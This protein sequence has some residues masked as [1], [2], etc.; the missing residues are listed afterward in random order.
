M[1]TSGMRRR[2]AFDPE[3]RTCR[4]VPGMG[5]AG[6]QAFPVGPATDSTG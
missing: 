4:A 1:G 2:R 6:S 3:P 5:Q